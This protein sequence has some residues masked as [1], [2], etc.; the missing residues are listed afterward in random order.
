MDS[1]NGL[2]EGTLV[3]ASIASNTLSVND[4]SDNPSRDNV[5]SLYATGNNSTQAG[6]R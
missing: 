6:D 2:E 1:T 5:W 3:T 4:L